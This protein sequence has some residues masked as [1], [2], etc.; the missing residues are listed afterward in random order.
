[1]KRLYLRLRDRL[2]SRPDTEHEQALIRLAVGITL[3][4]YLL[5]G[6]FIDTGKELE[7]DL[8][9]L[10]AMLAFLSLASI[11]FVCIF[12]MPGVSPTR[13]ILGAILD[14]AAATFFMV[15]AD[16]HAAPLFLVYFW[17]TLANG[18][19]YGAPYLLASLGFSLVGF[20]IVLTLGQFWHTHL[21][22]GIGLLLGMAVLSLYALTLV[23]IGRAHV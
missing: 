7:T 20:S 17:I 16:F 18:F 10:G 8:L 13:R 11:I 14:S 6:A 9:Y 15:V 4:F 12:F 22:E 19:R 2:A 5:P 1:M 3:F 21:T 23:K